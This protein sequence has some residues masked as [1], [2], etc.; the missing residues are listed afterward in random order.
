MFKRPWS[1]LINPFLV[2]TRGNYEK[3]VTI[4][5]FTDAALH[6]NPAFGSIYGNY[7]P[8]H[9][10]LV[11]A[12]DAWKTGG[13]SQKGSTASLKALL[14]GLTAAVNHWDYLIQ[15]IAEKG[16]PAYTA[17]FPQGH[18]P[19]INGKQAMRIGAVHSLSLELAKQTPVPAVKTEV[20]AYYAQLLAANDTQKGKVSQTDV[21]SE[22]VEAARIVVCKSLYIALGALMQNLF[23][24]PEAIG[25]YFDLELIRQGPQDEFT[26]HIEP[27]AHDTIVKRSFDADDQINLKNTG[28]VPLTF[29]LAAVKNGGIP[30][31][32]TGI[33]LAPGEETHVPAS[34]LGHPDTD[35]YLTV[36]NAAAIADGNWEVEL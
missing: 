21:L 25:D 4:S 29:Y 23:A 10:A 26:G 13:G 24:T 18:A 12:Y 6:A 3:S 2:A 9:V 34:G 19:F 20:D 35:K 15:G 8:A 31:G 5:T 30:D 27:M 14:K 1:F 16:T 36:Y 17:F 7:H 28:L 32:V 33:T 22:S 11:A